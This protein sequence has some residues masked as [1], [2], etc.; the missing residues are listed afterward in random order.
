MVRAVP[1]DPVRRTLGNEVVVLAKETRTTPAIT[2][3]V[4][5]RGGTYYDPD[6]HEGTA[7]LAAR[8]L[9]RGTETRSAADIA[10]ELDGRGASLSVMAGRHQLTVSATCLAEDF[11]RTFALVADVVCRPAFD[12]TEVENRRAELLTAILQD[13]DDPA[14]VAVDVLMGRL[15]PHHPYGRRARGTQSTVQ[16]IERGHLIEFHR[17][18]FTPEG[19]TVVVVG[20]VDTTDVMS[21]A[22]NAF[23][24]WSGFR[25]PEPPFAFV[26]SPNNR[27]F[28]AVPMMNKAQADIAYAFVGLKRSD[29]EYYP[30][31]V[32]NNALGQ[33]AL[34]GRLG[35]SI[36][37]RQGMAYYV[38][39]TLDASLA[40][41]PLMIRAGV[42]GN[43]VDRTI[44]SIDHE[45]DLVR[46]EGF[47]RKEMEE[48]KSYLIGSIPRQL[49]TNAGIA[50]FLLSAEFHSLGADYDRRLPAFI[51]AVSPD[52]ANNVA[53]RLL[54]PSRAAIVV[55]GPY[56]KADAAVA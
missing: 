45:L 32:M 39:S 7:A 50:G 53:R 52:Q 2:I 38:Y 14:A 31:W 40:E 55:A 3:L 8:V 51:D 6:G 11:H 12:A 19:T 34:G 10:D 15:Y 46:R 9:D 44:D 20:D 37:E 56:Q 28:V 35:D 54:D 48:S 4:G 26:A 43:D 29:P 47:T 49:E 33:Y 42:A 13:E 23:E 41:G 18:W 21:A 16:K 17:R 36:R 5:I 30:A 24:S 25:A 22:A 27:D 1:L